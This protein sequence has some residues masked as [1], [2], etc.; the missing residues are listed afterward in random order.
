M[1]KTILILFTLININLYSNSDSLLVLLVNAND[2]EKAIIY[3]KLSLEYRELSPDTSALYA[4][5]ALEIAQHDTVKILSLI[6]IGIA[7]TN[8]G[9]YKQAHESL[10]EARQLSEK[11][12]INMVFVL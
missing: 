4:T 9:L 1:N 7:N 2:N 11:T 5:K 3:N 8:M 10:S 6:N 12:T